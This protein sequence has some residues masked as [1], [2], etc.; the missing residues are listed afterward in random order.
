MPHSDPSSLIKRSPT[1]VDGVRDLTPM[2]V[3]RANATCPDLTRMIVQRNDPCN[4]ETKP[5]ELIAGQITPQAIFY[6]RNH[7]DVPPLGPDHAITIGDRAWN[8]AALE[9]I[10]PVRTVTA[11]LQCAG[12]RRAD[13]QGVARTSGDPWGIGAIGNATWTG[14]SLIDVLHE[15]GIADDGRFVCFVAAD[16]MAAG[17]EVVRYGVSISMEKAR[18]PDVL[19]AWAMN[20][21]LL[22]P[23]HGAPLRLIVPGYAGM[24]SIKWLT[25]VAVTDQPSDAP[26]QA[27]DYKLF[28]ASVRSAEEADWTQGLTID[29]LP[30]NSAICVPADGDVLSERRVTIQG[31]A[32][33]YDR[34]VSRVEI[35]IDDGK[36]WEQA[37]LE[38]GDGT[39]WAWTRWRLQAQLVT[40]TNKL[41]VRAVD[42][43]GQGQPEHP[44]QVWNFA[45]YSASAWHRIEVTAD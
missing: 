33:A 30:V 32:M 35:S 44:A 10:F 13:L 16:D 36:S 7:G 14:V 23:E 6:I 22:S 45:G 1:S 8:H 25:H 15:Q 12:N 19:L 28:P 29:L 39:R 20:G 9:R 27:H 40:G 38:R 34:G 18:D 41:I 3:G 17:D 5:A 37:D 26:I 43:S 42:T 24:R 11:T 21:E 4:A 31:Y 2:S